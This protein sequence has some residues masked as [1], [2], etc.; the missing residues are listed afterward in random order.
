MWLLHSC[1]VGCLN[2]ADDNHL[3]FQALGKRRI[4][5]MGGSNRRR[6]TSARADFKT[7]SETKVI[8]VF[9]LSPPLVHLLANLI[10]AR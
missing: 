8:S 10:R 6:A 2:A 1:V 3:S 5:I 9:S 7:S 4:S